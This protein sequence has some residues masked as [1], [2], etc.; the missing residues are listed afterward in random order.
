MVVETQQLPFCAYPTAVDI[1]QH[2]VYPLPEVLPR[3]DLAAV[4]PYRSH[5]YTAVCADQLTLPQLLQMT[6]VVGLSFSQREEM[7]RHLI[8]SRAPAEALRGYVHHDLFGATEVTGW[9]TDDILPWFV[10]LCVATDPT[11]PQPAPLNE[12][13]VSQSMAIV[14]E[15]TGEVLGGAF[16]ETMPPIDIEPPF[17][18][19][20][21]LLT[22]VLGE[23]IPILTLLST[24]DAEGITALCQQYPDFATAYEAG[25]VGHHFMIARGDKLAKLDTFELLAATVERYLA[26]GFAYV[27]VEATNQWTGAA[28][29]ALN[30]VRVHFAPFR[31]AQVYPVAAH[32][33]ADEPASVDGFISHKDSGSMFYVLRL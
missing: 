32:G 20:D 27:V 29:E 13:A 28:C 30:G 12:D 5:R 6:Q 3:V 8:P 15:V 33:L 16:N 26:L 19:D 17:R 21:A 1:N 10:R 2:G 14:D 18:E 11:F 22:A 25:R 23:M 4:Q 31:A 7:C 9:T 24:Q